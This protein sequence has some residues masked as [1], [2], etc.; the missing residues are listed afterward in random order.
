MLA[1]FPCQIKRQILSEF[2]IIISD[3]KN[4]ETF[5]T[6]WWIIPTLH[7][8]LP[9]SLLLS[10]A[11]KLF[12]SFMNSNLHLLQGKRIIHFCTENK[13]NVDLSA[14]PYFALYVL[15]HAINLLFRKQNIQGDFSMTNN[16][17]FHFHTVC[18]GCPD[19]AKVCMETSHLA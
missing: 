10:S 9:W 15:Q 11:A 6:E 4:Y 7:D 16:K 19:L 12:Y 18:D 14:S 17:T 2:A 1:C 3:H 13:G 5:V 8:C